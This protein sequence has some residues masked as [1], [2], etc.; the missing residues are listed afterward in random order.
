MIS[1]GPR[2]YIQFSIDF[3]NEDIDATKMVE[4]LSIEYL[5]PPIADDLIAE[6]YPREVEVSET[7]NFTYAV[8]A[9]MNIEGVKGFDTFEILTPTRVLGIDRI[10]II[11]GGELVFERELNADVVLDERGVPMVRTGD[12]EVRGLPYATVAATGDTVAIQAI[13][14]RNF[15][16]RFPQVERPAAGGERLLKIHFRGRVLLYSTL[17]RGQAIL[18]SQPGSIQRITPGNAT[19]LGEGDLPT[20][21]GITVLSPGI[22][23]GSLVGSFALGPN[24]F[25]PN[26]DG[27][28]DRLELSYD[29]VAVTRAAEVQVQVFDLTG[30]LVRTLYRGED[31]SG[32]YDSSVRSGLVWDGRDQTGGVVPPGI[33]LVYI[34]IEGDSKAN[35]RAVPVAVAY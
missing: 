18:S 32:R 9:L 35:R 3:L 8:R 5:R 23:Q 20:A 13:T 34:E 31:L 12:G 19:F 16:V 28:N 33:Y 29:I 25:T 1:P 17:F 4:Q 10:E 6:I 21:S 2:R 15:I 7:V 14:D 30:R 27:I 11:E 26:G 22:T 24:P